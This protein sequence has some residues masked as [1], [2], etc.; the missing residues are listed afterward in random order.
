[1]IWQTTVNLMMIAFLIFLAINKKETPKKRILYMIL[2]SIL[3][4]LIVQ[5]L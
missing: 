3:L 4:Q 5:L 2:I 1:M